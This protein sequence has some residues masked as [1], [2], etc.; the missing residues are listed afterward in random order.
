MS[1][2][3]QPERE[4]RFIPVNEFNWENGVFPSPE[5]LFSTKP[6]YTLTDEQMKSLQ[7]FYSRKLGAEPIKEIRILPE[8]TKQVQYD[9]GRISFPALQGVFFDIRK[10]LMGMIFSREDSDGKFKVAYLHD[11]EPGGESRYT[12]FIFP[13]EKFHKFRNL[14][15]D[16]YT[17]DVI[18]QLRDEDNPLKKEKNIDELSYED[19]SQ[20]A[21]EKYNRTIPLDRLC[22]ALQSIKVGTEDA[23]ELLDYDLL[24]SFKWDSEINLFMA[25]FRSDW[26]P[27]DWRNM[28]A[29]QIITW[30]AEHV[31]GQSPEEWEEDR[32]KYIREYLRYLIKLND[33]R[34]EP[35]VKLALASWI[36][37][38]QVS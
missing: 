35:Y 2:P 7:A 9:E 33:P 16:L 37:E 18:S 38:Q 3:E 20:L 5:Q 36:A 28:S 14:L 27:L 21:E 4:R 13:Q 19:I 24:N 32:K 17:K 22:N 26:A 8:G 23:I 11:P 29:D 25:A 12:R 31:D 30:Q 34:F 15:I 10:L 6:E 1:D